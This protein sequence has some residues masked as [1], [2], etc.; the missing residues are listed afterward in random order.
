MSDGSRR[1]DEISVSAWSGQPDA[2]QAVI[3]VSRLTHSSLEKRSDF[4]QAY[5]VDCA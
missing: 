2:P 3:S 4:R 1:A 5:L